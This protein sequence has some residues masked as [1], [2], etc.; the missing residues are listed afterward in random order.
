MS[1]IDLRDC[2][3]SIVRMFPAER[4][5]CLITVLYV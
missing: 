1:P 2:C 5:S 4:R 3:L